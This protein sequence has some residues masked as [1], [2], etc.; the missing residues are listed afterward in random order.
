MDE[1]LVAACFDRETQLLLDFVHLEPLDA[2]TQQREVTCWFATDEA[3]S[4]A[5]TTEHNTF[6]EHRIECIVEMLASP[7]DITGLPAEMTV[8]RHGDMTVPVVRVGPIPLPRDFKDP[9]PY[10]SVKSTAWYEEFTF[11]NR[12]DALKYFLMAVDWPNSSIR[13]C[14]PANSRSSELLPRCSKR[15]EAGDGD[16]DN[17]APANSSSSSQPSS[18]STTTDANPPVKKRKE[19]KTS[20]SA[21]S[22]PS[23]STDQSIQPATPSRPASTSPQSSPS[24]PNQHPNQHSSQTSSLPPNSAL[25]PPLNT[26]NS[27]SNNT[28]THSADTN[29][30]APSSPSSSSQ[31]PRAATTPNEFSHEASEEEEEEK[32]LE[33]GELEE[34]E[35][36]EGEE[37]ETKQK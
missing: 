5:A 20:T 21:N 25:S 27:S 17:K 13:M 3:V 18:D 35:L 2:E 8:R 16:I 30:S 23:P 33:E 9:D 34:G 36:E 4:F 29:P 28:K 15:K 14:T 22:S 11:A 37:E 12:Q 26:N 32:E 19:S 10:V 31:T 24:S 7:I 6:S 1:D